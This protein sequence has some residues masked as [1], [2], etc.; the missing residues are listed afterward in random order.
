M[1]KVCI[2]MVGANYGA[3]LHCNGYPK[4][5]GVEPRLK[6]IVDIDEARA[7]SAAEKYGFEQYTTDFDEMLKDPEIDVVDICT[8]PFLHGDM[9]KK[10]LMPENMLFAKSH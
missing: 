3:F 1:K 5:Y 10:H 8:P 6:T 9:I 2:G 4:V 7:K